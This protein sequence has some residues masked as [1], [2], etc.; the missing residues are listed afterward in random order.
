MRPFPN[1]DGAK[2]IEELTK[3]HSIGS[4]PRPII[5]QGDSKEDVAPYVLDRALEGNSFWQ[6]IGKK[7]Q[8]GRCDD[9]EQGGGGTQVQKGE[10]SREAL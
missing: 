4:L 9:Y 3:K 10:Q 8:V 2:W 6:A 1:P 5:G 7:P